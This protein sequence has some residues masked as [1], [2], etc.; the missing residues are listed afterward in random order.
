M[1]DKEKEI[2]ILLVEDLEEDMLIVERGF[3]EE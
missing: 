2:K 3:K 1:E